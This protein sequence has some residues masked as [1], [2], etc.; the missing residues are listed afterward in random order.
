MATRQPQ[1]AIIESRERALRSLAATAGYRSLRALARASGVHRVTLWRVVCG[2]EPRH[3]TLATLAL[4][5]GVPV[6]VLRVAL[7]VAP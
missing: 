7:G 3:E 6:D 4:T 1:H 5:L 2:T